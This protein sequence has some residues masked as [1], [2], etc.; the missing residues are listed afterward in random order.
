MM[1]STPITQH[2]SIKKDIMI[3]VAF[4]ALTLLIAAV[5]LGKPRLTV[6]I[7]LLFLEGALIFYYFTH[8]VSRQKAVIF[9]LLLTV[10]L[11]VSLLFWPGW[12]FFYSTRDMPILD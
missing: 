7:P 12:D 6:T 2:R 5:N 3:F 1:N 4:I 9:V 8:L 10:V 11:V